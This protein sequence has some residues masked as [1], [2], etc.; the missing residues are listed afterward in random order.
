MRAL[1][2]ANIER[3][4]PRLD[5][6]EEHYRIPSHVGGCSLFLRYL[7]PTKVRTGAQRI[8]LYVHGATFPSALS[9]AHRFDGRSWRDELC[10]SGFHVWGL[11]FLGFGSSDRYRE[12]D[13]PAANHTPLGRADSA[14]RQIERAVRFIC[15]WHD[16]QRISLIAH[17]W[18][19]V[20]AG[21]FASLCPDLVDRLVFF[22]P[23]TWRS[24][25]EEPPA[26]PAWRCVSVTDQWTRFTEDVPPGAGPVLSGHHFD[27]WGVLYLETDPESRMRSPPS[28]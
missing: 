27:E 20:A 2:C 17:S 14:N 12:M 9:I 5:P 11:D 22:G 16:V 4:L 1:T 15:D 8:V 6:R 10:D 7:P 26:Y 24:P 18:G 19:T 21:L 25:K 28:V 3:A 13:E 23:I